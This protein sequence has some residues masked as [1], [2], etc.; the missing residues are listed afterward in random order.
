[1]KRRK[2]RII[3]SLFSVISFF[4][5]WYHDQHFE[6]MFIMFSN[7][8][9]VSE[10]I[11]FHVFQS[12]K[13]FLRNKETCARSKRRR[14]VFINVLFYVGR[15]LGN[16]THLRQPFSYNKKCVRSS[17]NNVCVS[18]TYFYFI[19]KVVTYLCLC[20]FDLSFCFLFGLC[21]RMLF[22]CE[23]KLKHAKEAGPAHFSRLR[24]WSDRQIQNIIKMNCPLNN[25]ISVCTC[26]CTSE[27][28]WK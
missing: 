17:A 6:N 5:L 21:I 27:I 24:L 15:G 18:F 26:R 16:V 4:L 28:K 12:K 19:S 8:P 20:D 7:H 22:I 11:I 10:I 25:E 1:M 13:Y 23:E 14:F 3:F 2:R 9:Q